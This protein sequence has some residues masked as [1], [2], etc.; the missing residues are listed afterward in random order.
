MSIFAPIVI[1]IVYI[2]HGMYVC[3][4]TYT[5]SLSHTHTHTHTHTHAQLAVLVSSYVRSQECMAK[6]GVNLTAALKPDGSA[7]LLAVRK[8]TIVTS[9]LLYMYIYICFHHVYN[10]CIGL[11]P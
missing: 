4:Y 9:I 8:V 2:G 7:L 10:A 6:H 5:P 1:L 11:V 3:V